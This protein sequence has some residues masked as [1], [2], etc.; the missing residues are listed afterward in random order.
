MH[1]TECGQRRCG[2]IP[3]YSDLVAAT[4]HD[5]R[6]PLQTSG[7]LRGLLAIRA[8][9]EQATALLSRLDDAL[10]SMS[11][12]L[13]TLSG[14][15]QIE[16]GTVRPDITDFRADALLNRLWADFATAT[17]TK[18]SAL[19]V[20]L[21][22]LSI[23]SDSGLLLRLLREMVATAMKGA[24][25]PHKLLLGCRR[26]GGM[27]RIEVLGRGIAVEANGSVMIRYLGHL[28]G[29]PVR[30]VSSGHGLAVDVPLA[31]EET[32]ER[33]PLRPSPEEPAS[34]G[35]GHA[36]MSLSEPG[37][38]GRTVYVVDDDRAL[39][40][41]MRDLLVEHGWE[42]EISPS[43]E[44]FL[45][46]EPPG[47]EGVLLVDAV[48]PGMGGLELLRRIRSRRPLPAIVMTG[49]GDIAMAV[50]AMKAGA[51]DFIEKPIRCEDLLAAI[52]RIQGATSPSAHHVA[53]ATIIAGLTARE[54]QVMELVLAGHPSKRI[55]HEL[56]ISQRTVESH[57][58]AVMKKAG[59]K[60]LAALIRVALASA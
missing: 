38:G 55:A 50:D 18:G 21:S 26:R 45:E 20:V 6:Q 5:L 42:V 1:N 40:D 53:T 28:L 2:P 23:R 15:N 41:A 25:G 3:A 52:D 14:I 37:L 54:R 34:L 16:S 49:H 9:D 57:R 48:M 59:V 31:R 19:R 44:A 60:S 8:A 39:C 47:H 17:Q 36:A 11:E 46:T 4:I 12:I 35:A 33:L 7:L 51:R 10:T 22:S 43:A 29:H 56:G 58:A 27:L 24:E 13:E 32:T 30:A